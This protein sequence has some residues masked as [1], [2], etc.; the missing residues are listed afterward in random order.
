[1]NNFYHG[2]SLD[3]KKFNVN[4]KDM[5]SFYITVQLFIIRSIQ[6]AFNLNLE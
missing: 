5:L 4:M 3:V 1:M 2:V 6:T